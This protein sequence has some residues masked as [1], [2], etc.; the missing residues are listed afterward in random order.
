MQVSFRWIPL[1]SATPSL[2]HRHAAVN[3]RSW[4]LTVIAAACTGPRPDVARAANPDAGP[5]LRRDDTAAL[6]AILDSAAA[7]GGIARVPAG[8]HIINTAV[9]LHLRSG[10]TVELHP[11]AELVAAATEPGGAVV[12]GVDVERVTVRGGR[13]T[14]NRLAREPRSAPRGMG[15]DLRGCRDVT[16][17]GVTV[18]RCAAD[19]IYIAASRVEGAEGAAAWRPS[20]GITLTACVLRDNRRQGV[21]VVG[22]RNVTV[23]RCRISAT[24]PARPGAGIDLE[25]NPDRS[26]EHVIID[27]CEIFDNAGY[28]VRLG[29]EQ[30]KDVRVLN[31]RIRACGFGGVLVSAASDVTVAGTHIDVERNP[32][33]VRRAARRVALRATPCRPGQRITVQD[34]SDVQVDASSCRVAGNGR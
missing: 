12:V 5:A 31:T 26:V 6:Q 19:G 10:V 8:R 1:A 28:G 22:A 7:R 30:V 23:T 24:G 15:I 14:G 20:V 13:V 33:L 3:R 34:A 25:P 29:G 18:T 16:I 17:E 32:V 4:L 21:S 2:P 27:A 9:G 11:D